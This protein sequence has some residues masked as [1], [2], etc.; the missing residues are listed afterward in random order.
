[1]ARGRPTTGHLRREQRRDGLTTFSIRVRAY[2]QRHTVRLGNELEGWNETRARMELENVTA[3]IRAGVW[4]PPAPRDDPKAG[5]PTF[6]EHASLWLKRRVAEG[7]AENTREDYLWQ[8]SNHLLPFFGGYA[9]ND[10]NERLVDEFKERK[11]DERAQILAA[12]ESGF[13]LRDGTGNVR[14][15]LSNTSINTRTTESLRSRHAPEDAGTRTTS[16]RASSHRS[17]SARMPSDRPP[18]SRRSELPSHRTL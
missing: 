1:M 6:H 4:E 14:R 7:I 13:Q 11:L 15:A 12:Q 9:L 10:L 16:A 8:L 18:V 3:Q 2:G 17:S 5:P